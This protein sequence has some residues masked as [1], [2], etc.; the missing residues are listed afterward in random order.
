MTVTRIRGRRL[1]SIRDAHFAKHPLCV[2]CLA[3]KPKQFSVATQ[4]DHILALVNGGQD[5]ESNRQGLCDPCHDEKTREDMNWRPKVTVG[6]D[7][8]P[9]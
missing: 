5:V 4:L 9:A 1:Q 2:R 6:L 3:K 8:W 7:G